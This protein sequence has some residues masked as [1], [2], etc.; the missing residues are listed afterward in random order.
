M[1]RAAVTVLLTSILLASSAYATG[2]ALREFSAS[3]LAT[4][5]A[6]A[7]AT[8]L[9]PSTLAFNPALA[10][11]VNDFDVSVSGV[12]ILPSTHGNFTATTILGT[13]I[14]GATFE[15]NIVNTALVG[16]VSIRK[17]LT[18]DLSIGIVAT[19]PWGMIT[20]YDTNW[21]GRYYATMSNV[22]SYNITPVVA[23]Q[24]TPELSVGA[25]VQIQYTKGALGKAIDFG[26]IAAI[27]HIPGAV[28]AG[29]DG[30]VLL[31][32]DNWSEGYVVGVKWNPCPDLALGLSYRSQIDH[33]LHGGESFTLDPYGIGAYLA[34]HTGM[35]TGGAAQAAFMTPAVA[36]FGARWTVN[37][38][39]TV[40][41]GADW[42][43]WSSFQD[44][45]IRSANPHQPDDV[46][47]MNW[48]NSWFGSLGAEYKAGNDLTLRLGVAMD[49]TPTQN[50]WRT[51]GIP[52][53]SRRWLTAGIGYRASDHWDLDVTAAHLWSGKAAIDLAA[54]DTGN[55]LRGN[56]D[57][58]VEMGVTL[59]GFEVTYH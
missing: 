41:L 21:V 31:K 40:M 22:K 32:A 8:G 28:P 12:G 29:M 50:G 17:R 20:D 46:N 27:Y 55:A 54:T 3:A 6:G 51:P 42:M 13:P 26:T 58:A 59:F 43:G 53:S 56:L 57:G 47:V 23:Y 44:L 2:Y 34:A 37:D 49:Q 10:A 30:E 19:T 11:D 7:A 14:P 38:R 35:F 16:S 52:D 33:T 25:G 39:W 1:R 5:Y 45:I 48:K 15:R 18:D 4:S 36:T 9:H 24:L